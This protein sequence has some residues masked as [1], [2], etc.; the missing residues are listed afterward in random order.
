MNCSDCKYSIPSIKGL[1]CFHPLVGAAVAREARLIQGPKLHH[2]MC[3]P[4]A[5]LFEPANPWARLKQ[6]IKRRA[7]ISP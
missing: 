3:G 7:K 1:L 5:D 6:W 2:G 4:T